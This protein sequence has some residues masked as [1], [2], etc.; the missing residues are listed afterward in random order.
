M[1]KGN[2]FI[3]KN[4]MITPDGTEI[5]SYNRHN[6]VAHKDKNGKTYAVDG[7]TEYIRRIGDWKDCTDT[8]VYSDDIFEEVREAF[9]WGTYGKNGDEKLRWASLNEMSNKHIEAII[10]T[11]FQLPKER[12]DLFNKE[13]Q[14]RK[15]N[16]III[17]D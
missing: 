4:S 2:N 14:F 13:L 1:K 6:Y 16:N 7:G 11:Q 9:V 15:D 12:L 10:E 3:V 17:K 8:S 5:R